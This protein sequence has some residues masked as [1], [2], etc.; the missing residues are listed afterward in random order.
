MPVFK[1]TYDL[2]RFRVQG[3]G[4]ADRVRAGL[5]EHAF[6]EP[7]GRIPRE[8]D[9]W[10]RIDDMT[11]SDFQDSTTWS[12]DGL[13]FFGWRIDR[14]PLP[15]EQFKAEVNKRVAAWKAERGVEHCP[16][17]V[18]VEIREAVEDEWCRRM[19]PKVKVVRLVLEPSAGRA[20]VFGGMAKPEV[21]SLRV[22]FYRAFG[23][24]LVPSSLD[25]ATELG[26]DLVGR[27]RELRRLEVPG[28]GH[29]GPLGE[30]ELPPFLLDELFL[31]L[32][33]VS[34][35]GSRVEEV[36]L[37]AWIEKGIRLE[38]TGAK[39]AF[40]QVEG[41]FGNDAREAVRTG[42]A[43]TGLTLCTRNGDG[44]E[45]T[46]QL[47]DLFKFKLTSPPID[48]ED[49]GGPASEVWGTWHSAL[50]GCAQLDGLLRVY[51]DR[52]EDQD[53]MTELLQDFVSEVVQPVAE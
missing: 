4:L 6:R 40:H 35:S 34:E 20:M 3:E 14:R 17:A 52:R 38:S 32:W 8:V 15:S 25:Q 19:I 51:L 11:N 48:Y 44:L 1:R 33:L 30:D 46:Y 5:E 37:D 18:R 47:G 26:P 13:I 39:A 21:D 28:V 2:T 53:A 29:G 10:V 36:G 12:V 49:G 41:T 16:A 42:K 50:Q 24:K 45:Y 23:L 7:S 22:R 31:W 27:T 9:G 43:L